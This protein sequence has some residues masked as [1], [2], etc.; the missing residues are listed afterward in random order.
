MKWS[1]LDRVI[2]ERELQHF[3]RFYLHAAAG[4]SDPT[5][6]WGTEIDADALQAFLRE[7]NRDGS[8]LITVAHALIRAT[9]LALTAFPEMNV[10]LVGRRIYAFR[11]V[12]VRMAFAHR[13]NGEIDVLIV[14]DANLKSLDQIAAEVWQRLLKAGRGEGGRER[15]LLLLRRFPGFLFRRILRLYFFLDRHF[16]LPAVGNLDQVRSGC[17]TVNDLS[18][19]GAP[20]MR[21]YKPTRFP[22]PS[23]SLHLTLGPM[24]SKVIERDGRFVSISVMPLFVR[25]DHRL[26][27]AHLVG[28][29]V[30]TVRDLLSRPESL[31]L[32]AIAPMADSASAE[33]AAV[34]TDER[35]GVV[36]QLR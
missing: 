28:R 33:P 10:R 27:D 23:D 15:Y 12:N 25:A 3:N 13:R 29:F 2:P 11:S 32:P 17:V 36:S 26:A 22:D 31:Y 14:T 21:A 16:R 1:L 35:R 20:P 30:A 9:A 24:E 6:V 34:A 7:R 19:S 18:F 5:M 8:V 4:Q